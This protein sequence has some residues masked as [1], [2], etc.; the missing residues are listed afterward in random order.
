[1]M[2]A[3][4]MGVRDLRSDLA[5]RVEAAFFRGEVTVVTKNDEPR[6]ALIPYSWLAKLDPE[7]SE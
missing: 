1:M 6:A 2:N 3:E 4:T 7:V 5:H